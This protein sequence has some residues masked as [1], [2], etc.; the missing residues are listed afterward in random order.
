MDQ[1]ILQLATILTP[2][3]RQVIVQHQADHA[4]ALPTDDEV[5]AALRGNVAAVIAQGEAWKAS[6]GLV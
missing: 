5:I 2:V 3:I 4:G 6:K 1:I